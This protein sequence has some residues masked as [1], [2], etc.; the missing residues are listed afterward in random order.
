ML[1]DQQLMPLLAEWTQELYGLRIGRKKTRTQPYGSSGGW[2]QQ[3]P[4]PLTHLPEVPTFDSPFTRSDQ[5][6]TD[7]KLIPSG[8][9]SVI[10]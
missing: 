2:R 7:R 6:P 9:F 10:I 3:L 5:Q 1:A 8:G 4:R